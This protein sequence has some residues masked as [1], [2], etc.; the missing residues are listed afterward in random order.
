MSRTIGILKHAALRRGCCLLF[1]GLGLLVLVGAAQASRPIG[2][3][4]QAVHPHDPGAFTQ[5]LLYH[6]GKLY[7]STGLRGRSELRIVDPDSGRVIT[8]RPL[9]PRHFGEGLARVDERLYQ[10]TW[11]SGEG[12]VHELADL[13]P[14]S[15]FRYRGEGWGLA[16]DGRVLWM[17][18]GTALL[19]R[20][21]PF[22]FRSAGAPVTVR[23]D[24][25]PVMRLNELEFVDGMLFANV[26]RTDR[27]VRIDPTSGQV[28]GWLDL[29]E[30]MTPRERAAADVLNGIAWDP[31]G[32]RLMVTGKLWP[33]LFVLEFT[34][35]RRE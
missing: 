15:R 18:N 12:F 2:F 33:K 9:S 14:V 21:A 28:T 6:Q 29:K 22:G 17:S 11:T 16:F 4:I 3:R 1:T 5:G 34:D 26:W 19:T 31:D 30:L 20:W 23:L 8:R 24:G 7:E 32:R 10:L 27:I 25:V 13:S 35:E